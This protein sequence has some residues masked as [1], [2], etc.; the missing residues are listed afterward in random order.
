M[1]INMK[2]IIFMGTPQFSVPILEKLLKDISA[3][4]HVFSKPDKARGRGQIT[5]PSPVK[6]CAT[7]HNLP[8]YTP[9]SKEELAGEVTKIDP[10]LIIVV[11]Y[12][13]ILPKSVTDNYFCINIHA[14]LLPKYRGA[15][16]IHSA[17]LNQDEETGITLIKMNE[18]MDEGDV[19]EVK[20]ITIEDNDNLNTLENKLALISAKQIVNYLQLN[21]DLQNAVLAPQNKEKASYCYKITKEDLSLNLSDTIHTNLGKIKAFAPKPGAK[22]TKNGK[23]IKIIDAK[24][25]DSKLIPLIVK[26]EGKSEMPYK[27]Y[28]LGHPEGLTLC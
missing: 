16:P 7:N 22:L 11:A 24:I 3:K 6:E 18:K 26:P 20:N 8:T 4:F 17:L 28:L 10:D 5:S 19:L 12:A 25:E 15:S 14:S 1:I 13:M 27:D 2:N 21:Q 23:I 9:T